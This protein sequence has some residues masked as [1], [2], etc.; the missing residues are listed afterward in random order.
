VLIATGL[1]AAAANAT[2]FGCPAASLSAR[3]TELAQPAGGRVGAEAAFVDGGEPVSIRGS[4][5]FPMQSV[6]KMPIAMA[7]LAEVDAGRRRLDESVAV[8]PGDV[9]PAKVGSP[10]RDA[11]PQGGFTVPLSELLRAAIVDSDGMACDVLLR[12]LTTAR[13]ESFLDSLH[14]RDLHVA[15]LEREMA[16]DE[17]VQYRN[18]ATPDSAV[19]LLRALA[20]GDGLSGASRD[21]LLGWMTE[22]PTGPKRIKGKLP[23]GLVGSVAHKTGT[24]GTEG[25]ISRATNDV[26]IVTLADGRRLAIAVFV[27]DS[28][29]DL[30]ARE[31]AI[32]D[33]A[34]A[35]VECAMAPM[36]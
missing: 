28:R 33:I 20:R 22:T 12:L 25:G 9:P 26:G 13:V 14:V 30:A 5:R 32:A 11:H 17:R 3:M 21:R 10:M 36:P 6:Y 16:A 4:D 24:S 15:T 27:S 23:A 7:M 1:L 29:A 31:G 8:L 19:A 34:R 2:T 18:F 35:A